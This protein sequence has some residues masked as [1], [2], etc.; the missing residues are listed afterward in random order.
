MKTGSAIFMILLLFLARATQVQGSSPSPPPSQRTQEQDQVPDEDPASN[1]ASAQQ[2]P[3]SMK[4][5]AVD[6]IH[7][8]KVTLMAAP[9]AIVI[10]VWTMR[11]VGS[12]AVETVRTTMEEKHAEF[13]L[14]QRVQKMINSSSKAKT[15]FIEKLIL[16]ELRDDWKQQAEEHNAAILHVLNNVT[17]KIEAP[18][19]IYHSS[20]L[21]FREDMYWKSQHSTLTTALINI[22]CLEEYGRKTN[23]LNFQT[24]VEPVSNNISF[25]VYCVQWAVVLCLGLCTLRSLY[26]L[27]IIGY[28]MYRR[29]QEMNRDNS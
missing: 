10:G 9:P 21:G 19:S 25:W 20:L 23:L 8:Y 11:L 28:G 22:S 15:A 29:R 6:F 13:E 14:A 24:K 27:C 4:Q 1:V 3:K 12:W 2:P 16:G 26:S 17:Q 7:K 18:K 5:A